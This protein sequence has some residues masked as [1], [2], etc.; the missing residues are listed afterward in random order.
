MIKW[1]ED[2]ESYHTLKR[3][4]ALQESFCRDG[5]QFVGT[6]SPSKNARVRIDNH[7]KYKQLQ[8]PRTSP[9]MTQL[10]IPIPCTVHAVKVLSIF[11]FRSSPA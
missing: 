5:A 10:R 11:S 1:R 3:E 4:V 6:L 9:P 2:P 8:N 7:M